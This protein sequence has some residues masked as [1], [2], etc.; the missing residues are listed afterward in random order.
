[1][2]LL[3]LVIAGVGRFA[4]PTKFSFH[5]GYTVIFGLNETGKTT[6]ARVLMAVFFPEAYATLPDFINW[7][8]SGTSRAYVTLRE[9]NE[10]YR[11]TRDFSQKLSNLA[12]YIP[13]KK[14]FTLVSKDTA[15][16][17]EFL[18]GK[19]GLFD[20]EISSSVIYSDFS[21]LPSS[22]PCR[23]PSPPP[24]RR[25][26]RRQTATTKTRPSSRSGWGCSSRRWRGQRISTR[27][28]PTSTT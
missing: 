7:A 11:L 1:M 15:E 20:E 4:Q 14:T 24:P 17:G 2:I 8:L 23:G 5:K 28:S 13:D 21:G 26:P 6:I 27:Y 10:V 18:S 25:R 3:D 19:L 22:N 9:G 16:I 12:R